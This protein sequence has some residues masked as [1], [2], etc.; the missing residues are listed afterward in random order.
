MK[1]TH[2]L[3]ATCALVLALSA[4]NREE[5][6]KPDPYDDYARRTRPALDAL[7]RLD[8]DIRS[9]VP[10]DAYATRLSDARTAVGQWQA[11]L[12]PA[13]SGWE[14]A[15]AV[16]GALTHFQRVFSIKRGIFIWPSPCGGI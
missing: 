2:T 7:L 8:S 6:R 10:T 4:C 9:G 16:Q 12:T 5:A 14:S 1:T 13:E 3:V 15:K 11:T